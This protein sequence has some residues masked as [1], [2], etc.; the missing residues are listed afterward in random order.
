[1]YQFN[2][3]D[4]ANNKFFDV[5]FDFSTT[6]GGLVD[7]SS[8]IT[9]NPQPDIPGFGADLGLTFSVTSLSD[10]TLMMRVSDAGGNQLSFAAPIPEPETY[11][12]LLAGLGLLSFATRRRKQKT[13]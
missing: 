11:A 10:I 12:M 2:L 1:M 6:S 4:R 9:F 7:A 13:A 5:F 3:T 8:F